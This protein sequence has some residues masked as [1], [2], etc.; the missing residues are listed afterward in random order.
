MDKNMKILN[1]LKCFLQD[2]SNYRC[3]S[4]WLESLE[5]GKS[6]VAFLKRPWDTR[7]KNLLRHSFWHVDAL[8]QMYVHLCQIKSCSIRVKAELRRCE[9]VLVNPTFCVSL[10]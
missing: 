3:V 10:S 7:S 5:D 1:C 2:P 4:L 9:R 8:N 6:Y